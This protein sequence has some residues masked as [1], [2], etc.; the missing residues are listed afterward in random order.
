MLMAV[1]AFINLLQSHWGL[2]K[3]LLWQ[4]YYYQRKWLL[5]TKKLDLHYTIAN[6]KKHLK[7]LK[8]IQYL[9][10]SNLFQ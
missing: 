2:A 7:K 6:L 4:T 5:Q 1:S 10:K 8:K 9:N 3:A